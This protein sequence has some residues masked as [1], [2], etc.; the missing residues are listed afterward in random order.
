MLDVSVLLL[1]SVIVSRGDSVLQRSSSLAN[2]FCKPS[3]LAG[4]T[5]SFGRTRCDL[6]V[7]SD[8]KNQRVRPAKKQRSCLD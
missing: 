3:C 1:D 2:V 5:A 6:S 4:S 7:V 8:L